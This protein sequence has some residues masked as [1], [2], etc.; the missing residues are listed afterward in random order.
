MASNPYWGELPPPQVS[1]AS[2][3]L[4]FDDQQPQAHDNRQSLDAGT[5]GQVRPNRVSV[6]TTKSD[7]PTESTLSP[8]TSPTAS[9]F[10]G[11]GLA[12]RPPSLPYGANQYPPELVENRRK[13]RSRSL[14]QDEEYY[15]AALASAASGPPLPAA[16][17]VPRTAASYR[18]P[19]SSSGT[20]NMDVDDYYKAAGPEHPVLDRAQKTLDESALPRSHRTNGHPR[21]TSAAEQ[22]LQRSTRRTS[23]QDRSRMLADD[24]S[25]LQR[26]ELTLDSISKEDKRARLE[27]A[28]RAV[29]GRAGYDADNITQPVG[30]PRR[31]SLTTGDAPGNPKTPSR[32]SQAHGAPG[33]NGPLSQNPHEDGQTFST[34][35]DRSPRTQGPDSQ[36]APPGHSSGIPQRNLSFRERAAKSDIKLPNSVEEAGSKEASPVTSPPRT[37]SNKLK[38]NRTNDPWPR[39][40]SMS[41]SEADEARKPAENDS[42]N[43]KAVN[44]GPATPATP[45]YAGEPARPNTGAVR[46]RSSSHGRRDSFADDNELMDD[47]IYPPRPAKLQKSPSQR[48]ADQ[49]LG[50]V[51]SNT[52]AANGARQEGAV[53]RDPVSPPGPVATAPG[54][55]AQAVHRSARRENRSD[56]DSDDEEGHHMSSLVYHGRDKY[57]PGD[58]LYQPTPYLDEWQKATVGALT[59]ALL[60]LEDVPPVVDKGNPT[61]WE[62]PKSRTRAS[63]LSSRPKKAEAFEGEYDDTN[64]T[65]TPNS[66]AFYP[67]ISAVQSGDLSR[68]S[69]VD[70]GG[71]LSKKLQQTKKGKRGKQWEALRPLSPNPA[72]LGAALTLNGSQDSLDCFSICSDAFPRKAAVSYT[73]PTRFK[74]PLYL[75]CGPLLRYCGIRHER[76]PSRSTRGAIV[77][78]EIW[79]G[80]IMIVT[81]DKDSSYDIA[82]TLRLFVQ[83]IELLPLP[84]KQVPGD[85][86]LAPEYVDPIAGHPKLGRKGETLYVRPVDHLEP[87]RDVSRDETDDGLFEKTRS[88]PEG[89][90]ADPPGSFAAR[91]KRAEVDGEK[92]GKYKDVRG[93]RLHAEHGYTFWRFNIEI[94]LRDRQQRIAYRINR[95]PST[96]FWVPAKGQTMNIM[97]HSCNGFSLSVNPDEFTGPDPMWRDVLNTHQ[98]QPFHV[99]I[100]GGDQIY[101]DRCMQDTTLFRNW[102]MI[103]NPLQKHNAPFSSELQHELERFYME[104]YA[105]WFS[106]GL[107]SM[108]NSQIPMV[109]MYD[110]HDIIDGFGSY[111]HHFM[112]SPVFSGLGNVAFKYYMLFQHQ[113]TPS[114]TEK[115]EPSWTLGVK[116]GPYINELSRSLFMFLGSKVALLAVDART[117]RT[118]QDV[119]HEDTWKKIMDRCYQEIDKGK[120]EHLLVLLGVPIAYPRLV[121]LENIL[122][123]RVMDPIKALSKM[124]MFKGLLNRFDG[125]VEVL[126][127]L[128]DHWTAKS[129]KAERKFVIEDLQ[130]LAADKSIRITI[131]SGDVHLAAIGQF[132]SNPKLGLAKHRDFR[133]MPNVISSAIVNTPPPDLM[134]DILN[135][136]NKVHHFDKETDE[137]M[138][139]IFGHGVDSKPRNNKHLLPHRNW[140]AIRPYVPGHTPEPTPTQSLYDLTPYGTPSGAERPG[141]LR[142]LSGKARASSFRGPDS[143][144]D[145]SRPPISNSFLRGMSSRGGVASADEIGRPATA[146]SNKLTRTMS[147]SSVSGRING[148]F[149]RLS[150]SKK[151]RDDGG[152]NGNWG[153]DTDEDAI[154]DD[155]TLRQRVGAH[156]SGGV[157][158]RGGLG[159]YPSGHST[160][161]HN[162]E[163]ARGD[164]SHFT[165]KAP[166]PQQYQQQYPSNHGRSKSATVVGSA[167]AGGQGMYPNSAYAS[168]SQHD[169][170]FVP[171][172]FHRVPTGLST[173][174]LKHAKVLEVDLEGGLEVTLNVEIAPK[175]PSGSTVPYRLVVP[176]LWYEYEGEEPE[177]ELEQVHGRGQSDVAAGHQQQQAGM[178]EGG[179]S[180]QQVFEKKPGGLKRLFSG[181]KRKNSVSGEA[182]P[183]PV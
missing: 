129:H 90:S 55:D 172:P 107:F 173:K 106:Q 65:H 157:G 89:S 94:E 69:E 139:P 15:A 135:K 109:N 4:L 153:G 30:R 164:E 155:E 1:Q 44:V 159:D 41:E 64:G 5:Q 16:P 100:G 46:S 56:T 26:L 141:L 133:Y 45:R 180:S 181:R 23:T 177:D 63:S 122:T 113:S 25:P 175:D 96:G 12:P 114:E 130:D 169:K 115:H 137:D 160:N 35:T 111:P 179:N 131:L 147:G 145:R 6:Q 28:E 38:K 59:G 21:R 142:R 163:Y 148:L 98:S 92:A 124:G 84:P 39:R 47:E 127:D 108:A 118:R 162:S 22:S 76:V 126:D 125:G 116:P 37:A 182:P 170:G 14:E 61:W 50:R 166:Q 80:S 158:L 62:S 43:P 51:P 49:I 136:R 123:S 103:K 81:T 72:D 75:K 102:L 71:G 70:V 128:D 20:R 183:T 36:T 7:A 32:P 9:S 144:K 88:P 87:G 152:I 176:K 66:S 105:M 54:T 138:I 86:P 151:Q 40:V 91:R 132:Y 104:R 121:W 48:K 178:V 174:Q 11:Q 150:S 10:Q 149:R 119:L 52:A 27:A 33:P 77:D 171:K 95:G 73:T 67:N 57:A 17:D 58:G 154:Y 146:R 2:G 168:T 167:G 3:R 13:R 143:V 161:S 97:F 53:F 165:V 101:N 79:R 19:P 85:E 156:P 134:A 117:E 42:P 24:R 74:P 112:S 83:P 18:Y 78:R 82:P 31:T 68:L 120:V 110:D 34:P 99:M 8:F 140:C 29:R 60:D 93:F